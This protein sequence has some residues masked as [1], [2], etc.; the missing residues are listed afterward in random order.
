MVVSFRY[1]PSHQTEHLSFIHRP[2]HHHPWLPWPSHPT[3]TD[4]Q[5]LHH[6]PPHPELPNPNPDSHFHRSI[7]PYLFNPLSLTPLSSNSPKPSKTLSH[8]L[9]LLLLLQLSSSSETPPPRRSSRRHGRLARTS[10][11][12]TRTLPSS[13]TPRSSQSHTRLSL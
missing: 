13:N 1:I 2:T 8:L 5:F 11:F 3:S 9:L 10:P 6:F 12:A 7:L 4:P